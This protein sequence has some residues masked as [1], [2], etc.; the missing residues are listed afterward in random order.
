MLRRISYRRAKRT[1]LDGSRWSLPPPLAPVAENHCNLRS[2]DLGFAGGGDEAVET[3]GAGDVAELDIL[4]EAE[5]DMALGANPLRGQFNLPVVS[6]LH[7][8]GVGVL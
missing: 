3:L 2:L 5:S 8:Q 6:I 7:G 1:S 4:C